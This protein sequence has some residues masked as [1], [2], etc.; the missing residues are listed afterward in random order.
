MLHRLTWK[1]WIH[2]LLWQ[3]FLH[4]P[5]NISP[6]ILPV[7]ITEVASK[8][9]LCFR[10]F[11]CPL[12]KSTLEVLSEKQ[13]KWSN[14]YEHPQQYYILGKSFTYSFRKSGMESR[15]S[16][17]KSWKFSWEFLNR[18]VQIINTWLPKKIF[19]LFLLKQIYRFF[20]RVSW[21]QLFTDSLRNYSRYSSRIKY[22]S[23]ISYFSPVT[24]LEIL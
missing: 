22:S 13:I 4:N 6:G 10:N 21:K 5:F 18:F 9:F 17:K 1:F 12:K 20:Y 2:W 23:R 15:T 11:L 16:A 24:S 14:G 7:N 19:R 8:I 3:N